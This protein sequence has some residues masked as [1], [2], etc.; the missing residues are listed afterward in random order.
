[1]FNFKKKLAKSQEEINKISIAAKVVDLIKKETSKMIKSGVSTRE[2]EL[3]AKELMDENNAVSAT[4]NYHGFPSYICISINEVLVHGIPAEYRLQD[5]DLVT[6]DVSLSV[7]G[8]FADSAYTQV[9]NEYKTQNDK[10]LCDTTKEALSLAIKN[11][12]PGVKLKDLGKMI[13]EFVKSK[14]FDVAREFVGHGI[15]SSLHEEPSVPN[16]YDKSNHSVLEENMIIC[17]EPMVMSGKPEIFI[18]PLDGWTARGIDGKN[19]AHDEETILIT[20]EGGK[21]LT[22]S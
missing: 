17:I 3:K 6:V 14:G 12:K 5:G 21:I 4:I 7:D 8:Y 13:E 2:I 20:N 19:N 9:V 10:L 11:A 16:F 1:M 22:N 15:G 18:D